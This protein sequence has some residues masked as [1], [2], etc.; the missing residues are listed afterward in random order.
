MHNLIGGGYYIIFQPHLKYWICHQQPTLERTTNMQSSWWHS[1]LLPQRS[2]SSIESKSPTNYNLLTQIKRSTKLVDLQ[3]KSFQAGRKSTSS[4]ERSCTLWN[5]AG[6]GH[7]I[8][9]NGQKFSLS[10]WRL[11][12]FNLLFWMKKNEKW[13]AHI[14]IFNFSPKDNRVQ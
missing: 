14:N 8:K 6:G 3:T 4:E 9:Q 13:A 5:G 1:H 7:G 2:D 11:F 10:L 12:F